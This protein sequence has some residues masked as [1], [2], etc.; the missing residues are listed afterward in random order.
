DANNGVEQA[1]ID[2]VDAAGEQLEWGLIE[3][4][5]NFEIHMVVS[6]KSIGPDKIAA[7][8]LAQKYSVG[9][10]AHT[11]GIWVTETNTD[12]GLLPYTYFSDSSKLGF[13]PPLPAFDGYPPGAIGATAPFTGAPTTYGEN[14]VFD[15]EGKAYNQSGKPMPE[16]DLKLTAPAMFYKGKLENQTPSAAMVGRMKECKVPSRQVTSNAAELAKRVGFSEDAEQNC[17]S[18]PLGLINLSMQG[19]KSIEIEPTRKNFSWATKQ[20][21]EYFKALDNSMWQKTSQPTVWVVKDLSPQSA[22][23][24][25][26]IKSHTSHREG[27]D[28]DIVLPQLNLEGPSPAPIGKPT[29]KSITSKELDVD[30][31]LAFLI[32]SKLNGVKAIFL[33][34]KFFQP[35]LKRANFIATDGKSAGAAAKILKMDKALKPFFKEHLFEKPEFVKE[36]MQLLR[37]EPGHDSH[38][39]V[40]VTRPWGS[41]QTKDYPKWAIKRLKKMGCNYK[42]Q[43]AV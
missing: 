36:L 40:R 33:D 29:L 30:K 22:N 38:F 16:Y 14:L 25:D 27:I 12:H 11:E 1:I 34:K 13:G 24:I 28:A 5:K 43:I 8:I 39:H 26:K 23:G 37:H 19:F 21:Q 31:A 41:H 32:L 2:E 9:G 7:N 10:A 20:L 17:I 4:G 3:L 42:G 18:N 35:L 6:S 15:T